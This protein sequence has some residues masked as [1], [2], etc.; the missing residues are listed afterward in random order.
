MIDNELAWLGLA[1][2]LSCLVLQ[3]KLMFA[4]QLVK[5]DNTGLIDIDI[6]REEKRRKEKSVLMLSF[7]NFESIPRKFMTQGFYDVLCLIFR[8]EEVVKI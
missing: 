3:E 7:A 5:D 8:N 6:K 4:S 1:F 2:S